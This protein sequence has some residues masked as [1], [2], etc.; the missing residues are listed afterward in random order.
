MTQILYNNKA[1]FWK[2]KNNKK[3]TKQNNKQLE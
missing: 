1:K 2:K 3:Q